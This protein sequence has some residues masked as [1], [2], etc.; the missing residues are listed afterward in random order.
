MSLVPKPFHKLLKMHFSIPPYQRGY[1]WESRQVKELL[2]DLLDFI[3]SLKKLKKHR[4]DDHHEPYYCLQPITVVKKADSEDTYYVIDGQQRL[5]TIFILLHYLSKNSYYKYPIYTLD[6]PSRDVQSKYLSNIEFVDDDNKY[7]ENIDNFY[8]KKAYDSIVEWFSKDGHDRYKGP[9]LD[10]FA[11]KPDEDEELNDVR[12]IWY[13]I[14]NANAQTTFRELNYGQIPLTSTEL[15]KA[16]LLQEK[17]ESALGHYTRGAAYRRALEWD[18]MEHA[19]QNPYLWSMLTESNDNSLSHM[20]L[21]LDF[22]AD[23]LNYEMADDEGKRPVERKESKDLRDDFNYQVVNEYFRRN[24]NNSETIENVWNRIQTIFN[25]ISNWYSNRHWYHLIGLCR[26]LQGGK[27]RKRREF[28]DYIYKL[29]VDKNG[30]PI[31]RPAF[32]NNLEKEVGRLVKLDSYLSLEKLRYDEHND[33][34]IKV[35]EVLNVN[36]A[37]ND[38]TEEKRFAFHLFEIFNVT[39]LEHIH[40]QNITTNIKYEEFK[41]WFER[42]CEDFKKLDDTELR[43]MI[44]NADSEN[45]EES[46]DINFKVRETKERVLEAINNLQRLTSDKKTYSDESVNAEL[47][48]NANVLDGFFGDL[49]GIKSEDMHSIKNMA[50]VD[51]N[52]NSALSNYLLDTKRA[53]LMERHNN[54][55]IS[56]P[57]NPQGTYAPPATRQVFEKEYS[58]CAPGDMRLWRPEDRENYF[59]VIEGTYNYYVSKL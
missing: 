56:C 16:L 29:S 52:T 48:R 46:E 5:T 6:L 2:D 53:I 50:L 43:A 45:N 4:K 8:V 33:A 39:S 20:E 18:S 28:V 34:I 31:D 54:C 9:I 14:S 17:N 15:V 21:I 44:H 25:L 10:I 27:K 37:I 40:P 35:L 23:R 57:S 41:M 1:R 55:D 58:R 32:T 12:V 26:I 19:L 11:M 59:K 49:A 30:T 51:K 24:E 38:K 42:R 47:Q 22:V 13:E 36:D 3:K 7:I